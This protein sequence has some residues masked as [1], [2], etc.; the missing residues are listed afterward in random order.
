VTGLTNGTSYTFKVSDTNNVGEGA[1]SAASSAITPADA[2]STPTITSVTR[3]NAQATITWTDGAANGSDVTSQTIYVYEGST[4]VTTKTD[5]SGS[6]CTVTGLTNGTSYTFKVS[7]TNHV[8]EGALSAASSPVTPAIIPAGVPSAPTITWVTRG[9][10]QV[11]IAW[12]NG[13][14]N[15]AAITAQTLYVYS[16]TTLVTTKT[17][18]SGSPCTVTGLTNGTSYTFKVSDTNHVGEGALSAASSAVIPL[19]APLLT[20]VVRGKLSLVPHWSGVTVA[21]GTVLFFTATAHDL[22]GN[23]AGT[24]TTKSGFG[25]S[26]RITGLTGHRTYEVSV[27]ATLR[28]GAKA[29]GHCALISPPSNQVVGIPLTP[30]YAGNSGGVVVSWF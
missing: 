3:G 29:T 5:C 4:L 1:L 27:T 6:P 11:T 2:P 30:V 15:G 13:A 19:P 26:C 22:S 25:R 12:T 21:H 17:N 16:G 24:C 18:C 9:N 7:D 23:V 28:I 14:A 8:G 20:S 10:A